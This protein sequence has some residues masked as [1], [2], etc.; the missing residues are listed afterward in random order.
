M[1]KEIGTI[2]IPN[3]FVPKYPQIIEPQNKQLL[4][5][6]LAN[7]NDD[8]EKRRLEKL[9]KDQEKSIGDLAELSVYECLQNFY[10]EN[11][12]VALVIKNLVMLQVDP[13]KRRNKSERE[14]DFWIIDHKKGLIL[15]IEVKDIISGYKEN[16]AD[17]SPLEKAKIQAEEN[18]E[19]FMDWF[20]SDLSTNWR[21]F[22]LVYCEKRDRVLKCGDN[23]YLVCGQNELMHKLKRIFLPK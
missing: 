19:F 14:M 22:S 2:F 10:K 12:S 15:N 18:M 4:L 6:Q 9:L 16:T 7:E 3:G 20:R 17:K 23:C 8:N 13:E 1:S 11:K 21:Y 5:D